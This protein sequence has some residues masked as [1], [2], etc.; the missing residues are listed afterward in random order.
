M[1]EHLHQVEDLLRADVRRKNKLVSNVSIISVILAVVASVAIQQPLSIILTVGIGGIGFVLL[2]FFFNRKES[3]LMITPYIAAFGISLVLYVIMLSSPYL[4]MMMLP[5]FLL[6]VISIYNNRSALLLAIGLGTALSIAFFMETPDRYYQTVNFIV[7][8]YLVYGAVAVNL[9]FQNRMVTWLRNDLQDQHL[10]SRDMLEEQ[11]TH[12]E[13][14]EKNA[15]I[16]TDNVKNIRMQSEEQLYSM[17]EMSAAITEISSGMATQNDS[18]SSITASVEKLNEMMGQLVQS[19][20]TV[21]NETDTTYE[22]SQLGWQSLNSLMNKNQEFQKSLEMLSQTMDSLGDRIQQTNGFA[23]SI[24]D[25]A[26]QT[27]LLALNASIE[28]ARAGEHGKG[29]AVVAEEIR[30][31]SEITSKTANQISNNLTDVNEETIESQELMRD[32][33]EKM[34]ESVEMTK[35]TMTVFEKIDSTVQTLNEAAHQLDSITLSI[36]E[37]S[38]NI[39]SSVTNFAS[40]IEETTA[41]LQEIAASIENHKGQSEDLVNFIQNTD[42]ATENLIRG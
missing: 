25:I 9:F 16:I 7:T 33:A 40:I 10:R 3:L 4:I 38:S 41:S 35:E 6:T 12:S 15:V 32:N 24:Q 30:K 29:F 23:R 20:K 5:Y 1:S 11:Q 8:Y 36:G 18:A 26:S 37:S 27:N 31:L 42:K 19:A 2:L 39:E 34:A 22:A 28:A 14:I 13:L 21:N 17:N